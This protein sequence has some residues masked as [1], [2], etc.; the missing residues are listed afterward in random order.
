MLSNYVACLQSRLDKGQRQANHM[1][2]NIEDNTTQDIELFY[3]VQAQHELQIYLST[4]TS[5]NIDQV[6][7]L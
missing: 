7:R 6:G 5:Q 3:I 1:W 2:R 4:W